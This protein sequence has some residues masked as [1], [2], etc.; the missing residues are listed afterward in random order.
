MT[1]LTAT[2]PTWEEEEEELDLADE[3]EWEDHVVFLTL[4]EAGLEDADCFDT[5]QAAQKVYFDEEY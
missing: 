1:K 2:L 3:M 5:V 4:Q